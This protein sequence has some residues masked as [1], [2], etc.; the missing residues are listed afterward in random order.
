MRTFAAAAACSL[1]A[2]AC[3][4]QNVAPPVAEQAF[5][6]GSSQTSAE[7]LYV[8][9]LSSGP[10]DVGVYRVRSWHLKSAGSIT[11]VYFPWGMAVDAQGNLYVTD[12]HTNSVYKF[13]K[14]RKKPSR[15]YVQPYGTEVETVTIGSDGTM[16]V[17][18]E[19][20]GSGPV[21]T[22][23]I[24]P[25][26]SKKATKSLVINSDVGDQPMPQVCVDGSNNLYVVYA[27]A[28]STGLSVNV[29]TFKP[30]SSAG[31]TITLAEQIDWAG[32]AAVDSS[33]NL[34]IGGT[35]SGTSAS[36]YY[37]IGVYPPGQT[38]PSAVLQDGNVF[39]TTALALNATQSLIFSGDISG[40]VNVTAYPSGKL[41]HSYPALDPSKPVIR[42]MAVGL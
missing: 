9:E 31:T 10:G 6:P 27:N 19:A 12:H 28:Y 30:A 33:G 40:D 26:G 4:N 35:P 38:T 18:D 21:I 11:S 24:Y 5:R 17:G 42:G 1:F 13:V 32:G 41:V 25:K 22:V 3:S 15:Q 20:A 29:T 23:E 16:Y 39:Q 2:I 8:G 34:L 37:G 36:Y 14:G 7:R